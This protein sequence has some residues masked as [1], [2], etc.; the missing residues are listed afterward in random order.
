MKSVIARAGT[1]RG[2]PHPPSPVA[3]CLLPCRSGAWDERCSPL[4]AGAEGEARAANDRPYG[5]VRGEVAA[6]GR[7]YGVYGRGTGRRGRR[8]LRR[9]KV[10]NLSLRGP[11]RPVAIRIPRPLM[12]DA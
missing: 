11:E 5:R 10:P 4:R 8:P 6:N 7:R 3:R 12:P 1:A 2:N 9:D